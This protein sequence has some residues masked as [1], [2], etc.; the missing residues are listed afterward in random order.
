MD[1]N[2][3]TNKRA[4]RQRPDRPETT[5]RTKHKWKKVNGMMPN[6]ILLYSWI[7]VYSKCHQ[8]GF[9][10]QLMETHAET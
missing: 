7:E 9:T 1:T 5:E 4:N 3:D 8:S 6:N 10:Q 2:P